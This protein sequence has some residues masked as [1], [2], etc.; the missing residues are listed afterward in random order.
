MA[1]ALTGWELTRKREV[2]F[3]PLRDSARY[4]RQADGSIAIRMTQ[5]HGHPDPIA[6]AVRRR[7]CEGE[8]AQAT[9]R[10]RGLLA[11]AAEPIN[12]I[13][14]EDVTHEF[15]VDRF[16]SSSAVLN[17]P[18]CARMYADC[19]VILTRAE[20]MS[21]AF[22][23]FWGVPETARKALARDRDM[24]NWPFGILSPGQNGKIPYKNSITE[25][26]QFAPVSGL[27]RAKYRLCCRI[28]ERY[29]LF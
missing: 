10:P 6:E 28:D 9:G 4:V 19:G 26:D 8:V 2:T 14:L 25:I 22:K 27:V 5:T 24:T 23:K 20:H 17:P 13:V 1:E 16:V 12:I 21:R 18:S 11:T 15:P 3:Y 7:L 29:R